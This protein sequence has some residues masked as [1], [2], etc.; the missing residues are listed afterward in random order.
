MKPV[1]QEDRDHQDI[2][3]TIQNRVRNELNKQTGIIPTVERNNMIQP[4]VQDDQLL[5]IDLVESNDEEPRYP[6][7]L[8]RGGGLDTSIYDLNESIW[9]NEDSSILC[10]GNTTV[11]DDDLQSIFQVYL[12]YLSSA[13]TYSANVRSTPSMRYLES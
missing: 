2:N 7:R 8:N 6:V 3:S 9:T 10:G 11:T 13:D 12:A 5:I 1:E 4:P